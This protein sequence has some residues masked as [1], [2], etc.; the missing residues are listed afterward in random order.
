MCKSIDEKIKDVIVNMPNDNFEANQMVLAYLTFTIHRHTNN[1]SLYHPIITECM[2]A[3]AISEEDACKIA[4]TLEEN[5]LI[6]SLAAYPEDYAFITAIC[7]WLRRDKDNLLNAL[8]SCAIGQ[9]ICIE[10]SHPDLDFDNDMRDEMLEAVKKDQF[11]A[12]SGAIN[13]VLG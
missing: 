11:N 6:D 7:Q 13:A 1:Y 12:L 2:S 8:N 5:N 4:D 10:K 3:L 9:V